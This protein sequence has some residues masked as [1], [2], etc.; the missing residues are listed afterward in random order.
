MAGKFFNISKRLILYLR[1]WLT[2]SRNSFMIYLNQKK[3]LAIFLTGK[4]LR[5]S[6]FVAFLYFLVVGSESLAGYSVNQT[7]FFFL[8][9]SLIDSISQFLFREV[10][11]FR[12][13]VVTG[14]LDLILV[15]PINTLFRVL[16]GGADVIDLITLPPLF[17]AVWYVGIRLDPSTLQ[18]FLYLLMILNGLFLAT[19]FHIAVLAL[20]I[21]TLEIDNTIM[22]YRDVTNLGRLPIDIYREPLRGILT[23]L[24]PVGVMITLPAKAFMG[25]VTPV[26]VFISFGLGIVVLSASL[27]VWGFAL[28]KYS[29]ASS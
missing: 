11:R 20:G 28:K 27:K 22:I 21:V 17:F 9:F 14:D 23:Y 4:I 12:T 1:I 19:A 2:M 6:F 18:V 10:Y 15:K 8:T 7:L 3:I 5:F 29:S 25:L 16:M 26:G 24:I 13:L